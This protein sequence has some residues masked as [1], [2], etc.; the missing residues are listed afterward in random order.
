MPL[1]DYRKQINAEVDFDLLGHC[2]DRYGVSL[3][4]SI[5]KCLEHTDE[6][7]VLVVSRSGFIDWAWSS[8]R[9]FKAGA[10]FKSRS[11]TIP[12][13]DASLAANAEISRDRHG[14]EMPAQVWFPHADQRAVLKEM[15]IFSDQ[16]D[17]V[18]TILK[19]SRLATVW[20]PWHNADAE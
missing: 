16:Y 6:S 12:I 10:Y 7:A 15:K 3:T 5:L 2:A 19:L 20:P 1:D 13:P 4:A 9:A 14:V 11:N 8:R 17:C 18:F